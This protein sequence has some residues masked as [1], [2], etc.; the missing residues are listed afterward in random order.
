[1]GIITTMRRQR[2]VY[3]APTTSPDGD[4]QYNEQGRIKYEAGV[5]IRCRWEPSNEQFIAADGSTRLGSAKV[6]VDRDVLVGGFLRLGALATVDFLNDPLENDSVLE[7][8]R[9]DK[10]PN[11]RV[12]EYLRTCML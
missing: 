12:T 4:V 7:I 2:A 3:W 11:L 6:Y 5:E 10:T 8:R 9:F 1:M